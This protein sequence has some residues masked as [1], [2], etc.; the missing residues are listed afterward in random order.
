[1]A[2][3]QLAFTGNILTISDTK[4]QKNPVNELDD[5]LRTS[6]QNFEKKDK[7]M[8]MIRLKIKRHD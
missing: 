8:D 3:G 5:Q 4:P 2:S 1:M 6:S 7:E